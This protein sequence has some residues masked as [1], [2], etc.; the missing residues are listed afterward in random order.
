[1]R[2]YGFHAPPKFRVGDI[3]KYRAAT[4]NT[5]FRVHAISITK[6]HI[7]YYRL[8]GASDYLVWSPTCEYADRRM[9]LWREAD[10]QETVLQT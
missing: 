8:R 2:I 9:I 7:P 3:L 1:M 10:V 4:D 5:T 6:D